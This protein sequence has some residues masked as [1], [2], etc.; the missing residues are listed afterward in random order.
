MDPI[1]DATRELLDVHVNAW[2]ASCL[3]IGVLAIVVAWVLHARLVG[4]DE[5]SDPMKRAGRAIHLG[6]RGFLRAHLAALAA[7]VLTGSV[8]LLFAFN[9]SGD[10]WT[11]VLAF[12]VGCVGSGLAGVLGLRVAAASGART[13]QAAAAKGLGAALRTA[14]AS[15]AAAALY[16]I[17]FGVASIAALQLGTG[18]PRRLLAFGLG[19]SVTALLSRVAGGIFAKSADVGLHLAIRA[20]QEIPDDDTRN[21][22]VVADDAGDCVGDVAGMG[23]DLYESFA[24]AS[25]AAMS[26]GAFAWSAAEKAGNADVRAAIEGLEAGPATLVLFPVTLFAAGIVAALLAAPFVK[27]ENER[28]IGSALQRSSMVGAVLF[29]AAAAALTSTLGLAGPEVTQALTGAA[30]EA[31]EPWRYN[32]PAGVLLAVLAGLVL[33]LALGRIAEWN[34]SQERPPARKVAEESEAGPPVNVLSGMA[35]GMSSCVWPSL[36]IALTAGIAHYM[37]GAYGVA[38]AAVGLL[39]TLALPFAIHAFGAA[40]ENACGVSEIVRLGPD[41]RR[42]TDALDSAAASTAA[43]GKSYATGATALTSL[44]LLAT[45]REVYDR[46]HPGAAAHLRLDL[47]DVQVELGLIVGA[48]LPFLF[49]SVCI[50]AVGRVARTLCDQIVQQSRE[51]RPLGEDAPAPNHAKFVAG[52][53]RR[54]IRRTGPAALIAIGAPIVCG[55]S[56]LGARGLAAMLVGATLTATMLAFTLTNAGTAWDNAKRYVASGVFGGK[57]SP[58]YRA[59]VTGDVVGDPMKDA[60]GPGLHTLVKLMTMLAL[61]LLPFFPA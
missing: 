58:A 54:A 4:R 48:A 44:A 55:F 8:V 2:M 56:P 17:G 40:A 41:A 11:N 1:V 23:A 36:A 28:K 53:A 33:G 3:G 13:A 49:S 35:L 42:R 46:L 5:G 34:T 38:L 25:L 12:A 37:A 7:L 24:A 51:S 27:T 19:A 16:A 61:V 57:G 30:R 9:R 29:T 21:P 47:W 18:D 15:G 39:A 43:M 60:A 50:R 22:G 45:F 6:V 20:D 52:G 10:A 59:A 26:L 14:Y 31:D 32:G